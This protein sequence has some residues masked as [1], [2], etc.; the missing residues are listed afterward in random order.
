MKVNPARP[1][2]RPRATPTSSL[3]RT[4]DC[5]D[6]LA[7]AM[8]PECLPRTANYTLAAERDVTSI[9]GK[10]ENFGS[11]NIGSRKNSGASRRMLTRSQRP[12]AR[13]GDAVWPH[14]SLVAVGTANRPQE[15]DGQHV[16]VGKA[17]RARKIAP[18]T[19]ASVADEP[20]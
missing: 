18:L 20:G 12:T 17:S 7:A 13:Q 1:I 3:L 4:G 5:I 9:T 16:L 6:L 19:Q 14:G 15:K 10:R 2:R 11:L 8:T